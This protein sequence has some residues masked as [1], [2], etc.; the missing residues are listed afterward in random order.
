MYRATKC[1]TIC[2]CCITLF[3]LVPY[4]KTAL[5]TI[6]YISCSHWYVYIII[7]YNR[8]N[9]NSVYKAITQNV[10]KTCHKKSNAIYKVFRK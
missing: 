6:N 4:H 8:I 9:I 7:H 10:S 1:K 3:L 2:N 5:T